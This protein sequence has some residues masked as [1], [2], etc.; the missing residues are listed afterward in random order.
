MTRLDADLEFWPR[1]PGGGGGGKAL[2]AVSFPRLFRVGG[3]PAEGAAIRS[4]VV[5]EA[6]A[7]TIE[8]GLGYGISALFVCEGLL[9]SGAPDARH[10]VIDPNQD[11]RFA[12]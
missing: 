10:V 5:R 1:M 4:W 8:V 7:C 6:A 12:S 3:G 2:T 9:T 11:T